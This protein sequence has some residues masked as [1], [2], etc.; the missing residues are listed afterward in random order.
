MVK[1]KTYREN[2]VI[3][4]NPLEVIKEQIPQIDLGLP[5]PFYGGAIGY[6]G[7]DLIHNYHQIGELLDDEIDMPDLHLMI[8]Q[9]VLIF[10]H[11][12]QSLTIIALD[13]SESRDDQKLKEAIDDLK[14]QLQVGEAELTN[15]NLTL[16]FKPVMDQERFMRLVQIGKDYI[17]EGK[18]LQI[19]LSQRMQAKFSDNPFYLYRRLRVLNRSPYRSEEHTSELQS[20]GHLVCR[21]L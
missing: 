6:I 3:K 1:I 14:K 18:A 16:K 4:G 15:T 9:D 2:Q 10:D 8:Y 7:Y 12:K 19:V 11:Q 21:L 5:F 13:L 17:D 20:R